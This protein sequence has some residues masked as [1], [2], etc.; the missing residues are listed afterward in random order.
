MM[1]ECVWCEKAGWWARAITTHLHDP[2][3]HFIL[4]CNMHCVLQCNKLYIYTVFCNS[5]NN[6]VALY[7]IP[8]NYTSVYYT[9][10][11]TCETS[12]CNL[13]TQKPLCRWTASSSLEGEK[14]QLRTNIARIFQCHSSL[15]GHYDFHDFWS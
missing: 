12:A 7:Q 15:S 4:H 2:A 11:F 8:L 14:R 5:T 6:V 13:F 3:T 1:K 9:V 10:Q